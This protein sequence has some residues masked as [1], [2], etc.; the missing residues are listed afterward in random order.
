M[1]Q[2]WREPKDNRCLEGD[3]RL[4]EEEKDPEQR[5]EDKACSD[6]GRTGPFTPGLGK[7]PTSSGNCLVKAFHLSG[8]HP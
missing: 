3:R 4:C 7:P 6:R 2:R 5:Q 1:N 8:L